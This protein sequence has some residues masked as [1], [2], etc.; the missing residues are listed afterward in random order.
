MVIAHPIFWVF[1]EKHTDRSVFINSVLR[2]VLRVKAPHLHGIHS[3][4]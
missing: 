3:T 4:C 2:F 1:A